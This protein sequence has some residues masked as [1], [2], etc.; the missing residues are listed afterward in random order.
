M[1]TRGP[2]LCPKPP[3]AGALLPAGTVD[4][5]GPYASGVGGGADSL[6]GRRIR[7]RG[8]GGH[9]CNA[10]SFLRTLE[11]HFFRT[12]LEKSTECQR[13]FGN[14]SGQ[15]ITSDSLPTKR[16]SAIRTW[17]ASGCQFWQSV[18]RAMAGGQRLHLRTRIEPM[19]ASPVTL[20]DFFPKEY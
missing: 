13:A 9:S 15:E 1:N 5:I 17:L 4:R 12:L 2:S 11:A 8:C 6:H 18:L 10:F 3:T 20:A 19:P 14:A 7:C 16:N